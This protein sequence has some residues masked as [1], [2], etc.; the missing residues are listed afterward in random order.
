MDDLAF[1]PDCR[2]S[3]PIQWSFADSERRE[4]LGPN[5]W[6]RFAVDNGPLMEFSVTEIVT[7]ASESG[8]M[9]S[10]SIKRMSHL[11]L[12][13]AWCRRRDSH[14]EGQVRVVQC[15]RPQGVNPHLLAEGGF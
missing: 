4:G 5:N 11:L 7:Y 3:A 13:L 1:R 6:L 14:T 2:L 12:S 15:R 9:G 10:T 8:P